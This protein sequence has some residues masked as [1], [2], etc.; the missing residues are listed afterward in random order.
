MSNTGFKIYQNRRRLV[1]GVPDGFI[2][3]NTT[4][5]GVGPYIPAIYDLI[6][7][8]LPI[9]TTTTTNPNQACGTP[10]LI[11]VTNND[12]DLVLAFNN[13]GGNSVAITTEYSYDQIA[14]NSGTYGLISPTIIPLS[15][16]HPGVIYFRLRSE[17]GVDGQSGFSNIISYNYSNIPPLSVNLSRS[18]SQLIATISGGTPPYSYAF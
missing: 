9:T 14:W 17:C 3:P 13:S 8:P 15:S 11:S 6:T 10:T 18:G 7:C 16:F 12:G 2:E 1:N 5:G 4:T